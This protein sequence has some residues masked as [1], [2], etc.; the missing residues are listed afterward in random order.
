MEW[1]FCKMSSILFI[2]SH[3]VTCW[4][5]APAKD[6]TENAI[7]IFLRLLGFNRV[8]VDDDMGQTL[9]KVGVAINLVDKSS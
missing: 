4:L 2:I 6:M 5:L 3:L 7:Q 1:Y 8:V 9:R